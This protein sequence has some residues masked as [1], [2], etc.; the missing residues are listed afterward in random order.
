MIDIPGTRCNALTDDQIALVKRAQDFIRKLPTG[1]TRSEM[2]N[3]VFRAHDGLWE[4]LAPSLM[5]R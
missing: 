2:A 1:L 4:I 3:E 5:A